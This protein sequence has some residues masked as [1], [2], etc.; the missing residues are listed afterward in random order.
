[1]DTPHIHD[2]LRSCPPVDLTPDFLPGIDPRSG[3]NTVCPICGSEIGDF[4]VYAHDNLVD[5]PLDDAT[6]WISL[7]TCRTCYELASSEEI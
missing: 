2:S 1:M 5:I 4:A 7:Y 6:T 3:T